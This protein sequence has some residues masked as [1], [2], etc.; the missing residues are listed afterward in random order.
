MSMAFYK[1]NISWRWERAVNIHTSKRHI[2]AISRRIVRLPIFIGDIFWG[3]SALA[4]DSSSG[5]QGEIKGLGCSGYFL[6]P[7]RHPLLQNVQP[8]VA[9]Q[10]GNLL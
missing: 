8:S 4:G 6:S 10:A 3:K 9:N 2:G 1:I 5:F 7:W